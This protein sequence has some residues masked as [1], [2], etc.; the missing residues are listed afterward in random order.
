MRAWKQSLS[1]EKARVMLGCRARSTGP[2]KTEV[3][4]LKL[5]QDTKRIKTVS[6]GK[7]KI[8]I[9]GKQGGMFDSSYFDVLNCTKLLRQALISGY[10]QLV[11][12]L[13]RNN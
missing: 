11:L 6:S 5:A 9:Q 7:K 1:T 10:V 2:K 13:T 8:L 12:C 4:S 3:S